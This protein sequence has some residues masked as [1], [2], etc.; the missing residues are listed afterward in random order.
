ADGKAF[1]CVGG[2]ITFSMS[3]GGIQMSV[4]GKG[5]LSARDVVIAPAGSA[6]FSYDGRQYRGRAR[7]TA[8]GS[9]LLVTNEVMIDDWLKGV[10]P[11][12]IGSDAPL[13]ALKAQAVA[14]R[15]EAI[16]R[17]AKPPH[18]ED[19]FDFCTGPHCQAYKGISE[20]TPQIQ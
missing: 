11:A 9:G 4:P 3:G 18:E 16:F 8:R 15:S 19:G 13:E 7:I 17:L 10:L 12:E 6:P 5:T 20:E 1:E 14:G 2:T